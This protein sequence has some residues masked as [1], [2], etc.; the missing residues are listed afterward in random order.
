MLSGFYLFGTFKAE[1]KNISIIFFLRERDSEL[2]GMM[3]TLYPMCQ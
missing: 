3:T 1:I 2:N